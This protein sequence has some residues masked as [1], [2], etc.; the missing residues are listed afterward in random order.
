MTDL[1]LKGCGTAL[2][3][4]FTSDGDVDYEAYAALIDR[5][6]A[7][8]VDFLCPLVT[9]GETPTLSASEKVEMMKV[10]RAH[11]AG[12][13]LLVGCG[14]NAFE[15]TL[16]NIELLDGFEPDAWLV[17]VPF[18]NK[19]TQEGQYEYFRAV[20]A[21]TSRPIVIYNVPG[22]TGAN[23]NADTCIRLALECE[24]IIGIKEAS[25]RYSQVSE[26]IR[27][28]PEGFAV[29]SGDD[30][31]TFAF[32][33]TGAHGVVSVASNVAPA[34]VAEMVHALEAEDYRT[35]RELHH[36]LF[37]LFKTC[38]AEPNPIPAKAALAQLGLMSAAV[39]LPLSPAT[40]AT[41]ELMNNVLSEL[42]KK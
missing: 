3:T 10:A 40:K 41:V 39:R 18:Y 36:R 6:V 37:P 24:N 8:G 20:A 42:W 26:I 25:G 14:S 22:R 9:T 32:M 29:L 4:P 1:L 35:A 13:P 34:E 28:A 15:P 21:A 7:A 31:M 11:C 38:F 17:V 30:D 12:L 27:R 16:E 5:Q 19:P 23:M 2:V 33:A